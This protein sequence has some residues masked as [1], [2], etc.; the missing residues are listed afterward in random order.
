MH[1][2]KHHCKEFC[3]F[4]YATFINKKKRFIQ[5]SYK[6]FGIQGPSDFQSEALPAELSRQLWIVV[7]ITVIYHI[8]WKNRRFGWW[9]NCLLELPKFWLFLFLMLSI[10]LL[11]K[12]GP[13]SV[14]NNYRPFSPEMAHISYNTGSHYIRILH[15]R[16][17]NKWAQT[18]YAFAKVRFQ[19]ISW[20]CNFL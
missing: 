7:Q 17:Q 11:R 4:G 5:N 16:R 8:K 3:G 14:F 13:D 9:R 19:C 1:W 12:L 10:P 2:P 6:F 20:L 15:K 18:Y